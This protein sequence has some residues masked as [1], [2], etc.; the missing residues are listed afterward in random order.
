MPSWS[1]RPCRFNSQHYKETRKGKRA[2]TLLIHDPVISSAGILG[3]RLPGP[4][5]E[6]RDHVVAGIKQVVPGG[7]EPFPPRLACQRRVGIDT[8]AHAHLE[9]VKF[10]RFCKGQALL[11]GIAC[12]S[13]TSEEEKAHAPYP[14]PAEG[15][16]RA[17][18]VV[19]IETFVHR[20]EHPIAP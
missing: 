16:A 2:R 5:R 11:H 9:G 3:H 17:P 1:D 6:T 8:N 14:G 10:E 12:L 7:D 15:A 19:E 13:G 20:L 4:F 18:D